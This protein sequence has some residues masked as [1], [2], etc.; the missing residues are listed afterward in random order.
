MRLFVLLCTAICCFGQIVEGPRS[1]TLSYSSLNNGLISYWKLDETSGTRIDSEPT[2][3]PQNLTDINS[4]GYTNGIIGN[5]ASFIKANT[6]YLSAADSTDLSTFASAACWLRLRTFV[7]S[8]TIMGQWTTLGSQASWRT[9][10]N[11]S[12]GKFEFDVSDD[13][14]TTTSQQATAFGTPVTNVLMFVYVAYDSTNNTISISVNDGT[15]NSQA[16]A[17][18]LHDSTGEF[19]FGNSGSGSTLFDGEIDEAALYNRVL[20][21]NEVTRLYNL[22]VG[23]TCCPFTP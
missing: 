16:Y 19:R 2:G 23:K 9:Y 10:L 6:E 13:G 21:T 7:T 3:T 20:T 8:T 14:V 15:V 11:A 4:V 5:A 18:G 17:L 12:T 22:G 1:V